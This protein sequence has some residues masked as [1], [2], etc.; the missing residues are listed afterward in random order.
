MT[1]P[2]IPR[3]ALVA[4]TIAVATIVG[5]GVAVASYLSSGMGHM[6]GATEALTRA[7]SSQLTEPLESVLFTA[8]HLD[9]TAVALCRDNNL[10]VR[11]FSIRRPGSLLNVVLGEREGT[12]M[13]C[14][15]GL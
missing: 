1:L 6:H 3:L 11:V 15:D 13:K 14:G 12:L 8:W 2:R 9:A 10:P 5:L 4:W 7:G